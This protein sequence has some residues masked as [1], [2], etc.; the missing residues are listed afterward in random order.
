MTMAKHRIMAV[1]F[2]LVLALAP[3]GALAEGT[4][5][6]FTLKLSDP[7]IS[8]TQGG[9]TTTQDLTGLAVQLGGVLDTSDEANP[10]GLL[11]L[12]LLANDEPAA[13]G[14][15]GFNAEH[16]YALVNGLSNLLTVSLEDAMDLIEESGTD[17][18]PGNLDALGQV[19]ELLDKIEFTE[20]PA[21]SVT[22]L[23]STATCPRYSAT[24]NRD[25]LSALLFNSAD[26]PEDVRL[27]VSYFTDDAGNLRAEGTFKN[28]DDGA[29]ADERDINFVLLAELQDDSSFQLGGSVW[30]DDTEINL[31][32]KGGPDSAYPDYQSFEGVIE[33]LD[34]DDEPVQ[35]QISKSVGETED[36]QLA[37]TFDV[38]G[39]EGEQA[40][41]SIS[42]VSL[43]TETSE[44]YSLYISNGDESEAFALVYEG[45][46]ARD[47]E[48]SVREG[49]LSLGMLDGG[50]Q[51]EG[52]L[53]VG[54]N[55]SPTA[56]G[57]L[58]DLSAMPSID[59][60]QLDDEQME[61]LTA[62]GQQLLIQA[63]GK[64]MTVP[65]VAA[66]ISS[67]MQSSDLVS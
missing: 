26:L 32:A 56:A 31:E 1:L 54:L 53:N 38:F 48:D 60:S 44:S 21:E 15:L 30:G 40:V 22:F 33:I 27:D 11:S 18:L 46:I 25:E 45:S 67:A 57:K 2:A 10:N 42:G 6:S 8:I 7:V 66:L 65:S 5:G 50:T 23:N 13:S 34:G 28:I 55:L 4:E 35:I 43:A 36:G 47:G 24:L 14:M 19:P 20:G 41:F 59:I 17:A 63:M 37:D 49:Q 52:T 58:P 64:L 51:T 3:A 61:Q 62:E 39:F 9:E 29:D 12:M 16:V